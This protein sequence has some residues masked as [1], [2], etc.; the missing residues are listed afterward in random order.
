MSESEVI[1]LNTYF[2][3]LVTYSHKL[4]FK[5]NT[6]LQVLIINDLLSFELK[7]TGAPVDVMAV[8]FPLIKHVFVISGFEF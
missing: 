5:K 6:Q 3:F 1:I 8:F 4:K 2:M 7:F